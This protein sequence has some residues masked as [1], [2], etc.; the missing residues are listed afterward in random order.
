MSFVSLQNKTKFVDSV[1]VDQA[2]HVGDT[3]IWAFGGGGGLFGPL[4]EPS[5]QS[6]P[7]WG[8]YMGALKPCFAHL[9]LDATRFYYSISLLLFT[10]LQ[11]IFVGRCFWTYFWG[12][13]SPHKDNFQN[14]KKLKISI[15]GLRY[16]NYKTKFMKTSKEAISQDFK[17]VSK[18]IIIMAKKSVL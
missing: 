4:F 2:V 13:S 12:F 1:S 8:W 16:N 9:Y 5:H 15:F 10:F 6:G 17:T 3:H 7:F 11:H 18:I 14:Q